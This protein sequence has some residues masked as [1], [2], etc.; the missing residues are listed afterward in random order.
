MTPA[1]RQLKRIW[2]PAPAN[3]AQVVSPPKGF[4]LPSKSTIF[5]LSHPITNQSI[6]AP[7]TVLGGKFPVRNEG[8][9]WHPFIQPGCGAPRWL[10]AEA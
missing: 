9:G 6:A 2:S 7:G 5:H 10:G 1:R 8:F 4:I 3:K